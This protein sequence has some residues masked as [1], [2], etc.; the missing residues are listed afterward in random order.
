MLKV[1][2]ASK[3]LSKIKAVEAATLEVLPSAVVTPCPVQPSKQQPLSRLQTHE[4]AKDRINLMFR[5]NP[6]AD[7]YVALE[8]GV[9]SFEG[10]F[11]T[12]GVVRLWEPKTDY[13]IVTETARCPIPS[14]VYNELL[15]N[16]SLELGLLIDQMA[17]EKNMK[18]WNGAVGFL[19]DGH[20]RRI[21]LFM[22][23]CIIAFSLMSNKKL[24]K[25][26]RTSSF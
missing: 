17:G 22:Q 16:H 6:T 5:K 7:Y 19:T 12:F 8:G 10:C 11:Y 3:N 4:F 14:D 15:E 24:D 2:V 9:E 21:D 13:T 25:Y 1:L 26:S 20:L 18:N 23:A